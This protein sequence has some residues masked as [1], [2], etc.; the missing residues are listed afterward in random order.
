M[1]KLEILKFLD[2]YATE[3]YK[4]ETASYVADMMM[5]NHY[6][7]IYNRNWYI[8]RESLFYMA[9]DYEKIKYLIEHDE[10]K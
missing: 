9:N 6:V 8:P 2:E 4:N 5:L 3:E 10:D 7:K 1:T